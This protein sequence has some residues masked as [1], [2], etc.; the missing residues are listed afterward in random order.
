M[1]ADA[2][3]GRG[4]GH[5]RPVKAC[6]AAVVVAVWVL[7]APRHAVA[8]EVEAIHFRYDAPPECPSEGE[9]HAIAVNMG[10]PYRLASADEPARSL[11]VV[12]TRTGKG[13]SGSLSVQSV[14][15]EQRVRAVTCARCESVVRAL[16]LFVAMAITTNAAAESPVAESSSS[17]SPSPEPAPAEPERRMESGDDPGGV[18]AMALWGRFA[19]GPSGAG[20]TV[21]APGPTRLGAI[22]AFSSEEVNDAQYQISPTRLV[23]TGRGQS[24]RL[25]AVAAWGAPWDR[26]DWAGFAAEAGVRAGIVNGA[27]WRTSQFCAFGEGD[28]DG[29]TSASGTSGT[30]TPRTWRFASAYLAGTITLQLLPSLPLRPFLGMTVVWSGD[31]HGNSAAYFALDAG[32]AWRSR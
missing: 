15:G 25:G 29:C 31:Y 10:A 8:G 2:T 21:V 28:A 3:D 16:G 32:I 12:V 24:V 11:D 27:V 5:S 18:S 23:A 4:S 26:E 20:M 22:A 19:S 7:L 6:C 17:P 14:T 30:G 9:L 13:F 1:I